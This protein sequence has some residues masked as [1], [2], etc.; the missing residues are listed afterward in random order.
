MLLTSDQQTR[1]NRL[2]SILRKKPPEYFAKTKIEK[3]SNCD[4]TGLV[5]RGEYND[6]S[7]DCNSYCDKCFG[8]GYL[9]IGEVFQ[10]DDV[11][12][13]CRKCNGVGCD[14]CNRGFT[15]WVSHIMGR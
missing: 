12:F 13:L 11:T 9:G 4:G 3:C 8:V 14:D 6:F 10:I 5:V 1:A 7:W 15:D 2:F